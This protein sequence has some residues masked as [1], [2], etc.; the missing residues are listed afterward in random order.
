MKIYSLLIVF[1]VILAFFAGYLGFTLNTEFDPSRDDIQALTA[2][3]NEFFQRTRAIDTI[4]FSR[5]Y[6]EYLKRAVF[7]EDPRLATKDQLNTLKIFTSNED[8]FKYLPKKPQSGR[9]NK[10]LMWEEVRCGIKSQIPSNFLTTAPFMHPSGLSYAYLAYLFYQ[11]RVQNEKW[12][13][14]YL[15]YFHVH[16]LK[17]L[18]DDGVD[19]PRPYNYLSDTISGS[20]KSFLQRQEVILSRNYIMFLKWDIF[21]F[22]ELRYIVYPRE[23]FEEQFA[24]SDYTFSR[25]RAGKKCLY[26]EGELCWNFSIAHMVGQYSNKQL[27][28][29]ALTLMGSVFLLGFIFY[30]LKS[31]QKDTDRRG[32]AFRILSHEL[33]TP[34]ASLLLKVDKILR[35]LHQY[36]ESDQEELLKLSADIHRLH[37]LS[38]MSKHY[39]TLNSGQ[40][41]LALNIKEIESVQ[42]LMESYLS[43]YPEV[44]LDLP[45]G[46]FSLKTDTFW[47][48]ICVKNLVKNAFAHGKP[49]VKIKLKKEE[50]TVSIEVEDQ[51]ECHFEYL[52]E[53]IKEFKKSAKS[54]GS[55]LG[56][57]I[58]S[59]IV[60]VMG[61]KLEFSKKPTRFKI[62]MKDYL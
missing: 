62:V 4:N 43:E 18:D 35:N 48:G 32:L 40:H 60:K 25:F 2:Q 9:L 29:L 30:R 1:V 47:L 17:K 56:L 42:D 5:V 23:N 11:D 51:G 14:P 36:N 37:R 22:G 59:K 53:M 16:E 58:V 21:S 49:P 45:S 33:R 41:L 10:I 31:E 55:G 13:L 39:L 24:G 34:I 3:K 19:L 46:D 54:E 61:H 26:R 15:A 27:I 50:M 44:Q 28:F 12:Y 8:C 52:S 57:N 6:P 20:S 38:E 7:S